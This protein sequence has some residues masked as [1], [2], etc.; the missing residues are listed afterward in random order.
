MSLSKRTNI[1]AAI[2]I[3]VI[4]FNAQIVEFIAGLIL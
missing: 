4:T 3:V 2:V 1:N